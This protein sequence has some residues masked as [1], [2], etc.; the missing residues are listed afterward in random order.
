MIYRWHLSHSIRFNKSPPRRKGLPGGGGGVIPTAVFQLNFTSS[1]A[2]TTPI[3]GSSSYPLTVRGSPIIANDA[4]AGYVLTCTSGSGFYN[5][6]GLILASPWTMTFWVKVNSTDPNAN[7]DPLSTNAGGIWLNI[8]NLP[9]AA[10]PYRVV[11]T[12]GGGT[13]GP[14]IL[15][16]IYTNKWHFISIVFTGTISRLYVDG[17]A[18]TDY[19]TTVQLSSA[20]NIGTYSSDNVNG[21]YGAGSFLY[22]IRM[23]NTVLSGTNINTLMTTTKR[24]GT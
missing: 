20:V 15:S 16:A 24:A 22:D 3:I 19:S 6:P 4:S 14:L 10:P 2:P 1:T 23:Y 12:Y 5:V 17:V 13:S 11:F 18:S 21:G 8:A 9:S 7:I